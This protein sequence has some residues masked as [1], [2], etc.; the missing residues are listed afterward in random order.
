VEN[1]SVDSID[2][3]KLLNSEWLFMTDFPVI[4]KLTRPT[5]LGLQKKAL[6]FTQ[7]PGI[8]LLSTY[9]S[10]SFDHQ[11]CVNHPILHL[12]RKE[13]FLEIE[14]TRL[15]FHPSMALLRLI[16]VSRGEADRFLQATALQQGDIFFDATLGLGTDA[17]VAAW[18][19]GE[20]GQVIAIEHSPILAALI[21]DG[22]Y[23]LAHGPIPRVKNP[24]K[25]N[26]W[27]SLAQ[28]A[29]RIEVHL[30]DHLDILTHMPSSSVDVIYFDPMFRNTR[31]QSASIRPL[32][33]VSLTQPLQKETILQACR[34]ARKRV[35]LKERKGS[36]E[37]ARLGFSLLE[38]GKYSHVDYGIILC[39]EELS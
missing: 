35:I 7:Q 33:H 4:L 24:D 14:N 16:Q 22:L 8:K 21:S 28:A 20:K 1:L 30:G 3:I 2:K 29:N 11:Q 15:S 10:S 13:T 9:E 34:V 6:W 26:A 39:R 37:F 38:G 27:K 25:E 32:H 5:D 17:L 31:E 23:T 19:V 36:K 18:Q 12:T